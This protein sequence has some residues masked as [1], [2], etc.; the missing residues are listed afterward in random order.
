V[1]P[2]TNHLGSWYKLVKRGTGGVLYIDIPTPEGQK[3]VPECRVCVRSPLSKQPFSSRILS[4]LCV[5]AFIVM[6]FRE[7]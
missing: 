4:R 3:T 5:G 7:N 1:F 2:D 6:K